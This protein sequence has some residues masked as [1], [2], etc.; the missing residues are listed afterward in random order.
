MYDPQYTRYTIE[1]AT[2]QPSVLVNGQGLAA[3]WL[4]MQSV[5]LPAVGAKTFLAAG[6]LGVFATVVMT[7]LVQ[8]GFHHV[9]VYRSSII[10]LFELVAGAA[11]AYWLAHEVPTTNEWAGGVI[12]VLGAWLILRS[13]RHINDHV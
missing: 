4:G 6:L 13:A 5:A 2:S 10:L 7:L 3:I 11:S 12:I 9:P 1:L 8:Y